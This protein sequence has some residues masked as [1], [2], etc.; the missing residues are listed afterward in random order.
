MFDNLFS[1][2][3]NSKKVEGYGAG[4]KFFLCDDDKEI[5]KTYKTRLSALCVKHGIDFEIL[6]YENGEQMLFD[7]ELQKRFIGVIFLDINMPDINGIT[8]ARMLRDYGCHSEL[9]F[10]TVSKRHFLNAFDVGAFNYILK[11][12]TSEKRFEEVFLKAVH[13]VREKSEEFILLTGGGE[14]RSIAI[15]SIQYFEVAKRIITVHYEN[16]CFQ[17]FSS[18]GKVENQLYDR[19]FIRIHRAFL[20]S[21]TAIMNV[22][23]TELTLRDGTIL[24]V[25][26]KYYYVLKTA[27]N[28][29]GNTVTLL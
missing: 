29:F 26:R 5:L 27:F 20:V 23:Y 14:Y 1:I 21:L 8:V 17:F 13:A 16:E 3:Y 7:F 18:I 11:D 6:C 12:E 9:I 2:S 10:L 25:G 28:K 15:K 19:G 24:P 22:T 4:M